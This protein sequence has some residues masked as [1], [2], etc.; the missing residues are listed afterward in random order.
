MLT[1]CRIPNVGRTPW[2]ARHRCVEDDHRLDCRLDRRNRL[3][4]HRGTPFGSRRRWSRP[5]ASL[6]RRAGPPRRLAPTRPH[7]EVVVDD[8]AVGR[9]AARPLVVAGVVRGLVGLHRPLGYHV[10]VV[11]VG[12]GRTRGVSRLGRP[13]RL[14]PIVVDGSM[15]SLCPLVVSEDHLTIKHYTISQSYF[16][17]LYN[18]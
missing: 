3:G 14:L 16:T 8:V 11:V 1:F 2:L 4:C 7:L 10:V 9:V 15:C 17:Y 5:V 13:R 6:R 18:S 12:S